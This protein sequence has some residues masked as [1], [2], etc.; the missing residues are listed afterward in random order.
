MSFSP[1]SLLERVFGMDTRD[2]HSLG[3]RVRRLEKWLAFNRP[4][5]KIFN[6]YDMV[7]FQLRAQAHRPAPPIDLPMVLVAQVQRSGGSLLMQL[8][9]GHPA[10]HCYPNELDHLKGLG[11]AGW[12][13][14]LDSRPDAKEVVDQWLWTTRAG[15]SKMSG[16]ASHLRDDATYTLPFFFSWDVFRTVYQRSLAKAQ[17]GR[18]VLSAYFAAFFAAWLNN[19]NGHGDKKKLVA[20]APGA[21]DRGESDVTAFLEFQ[22]TGVLVG[23]VRDPFSWYASARKHSS[24]YGTLPEAIGLWKRQTEV[25]LDA[26]QQQPERVRV[27]MFQD[28]LTDPAEITGRLCDW[29]T[30]DRHPITALPSFNGQPFWSNSSFE[31]SKG[32]VKLD[33]LNRAKESLSTEDLAAIATLAGATWERAQH[34][35]SPSAGAV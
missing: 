31:V 7:E 10:L 32:E 19:T 12:A 29:L 35:L 28:L 6:G 30:L 17:G 9:D 21:L 22:P 1:S 27:F 33:P 18:Q 2:A 24:K 26:A 23:L 11:P 8:L 34:A 13:R 3:G 25:L 14:W 16:S 15:Y 5:L 4:R 20:F